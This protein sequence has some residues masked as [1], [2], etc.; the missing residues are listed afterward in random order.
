MKN[1]ENKDFLSISEKCSNL[2]K[3]SEKIFTRECSEKTGGL[4][5]L[6]D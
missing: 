6:T 4:N 3:N 1:F 2:Y 5:K